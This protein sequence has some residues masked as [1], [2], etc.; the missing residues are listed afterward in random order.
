MDVCAFVGVAPRGP[1]RAPYTDEDWLESGLDPDRLRGSLDDSTCVDPA[2][3]RRRSV[4]VAV[5]SWD[6]YTRLF[7]GFEGPGRLPYAVAAY[8]NQGGRRAYI[9]RIVHDYGDGSD[10]GTA[11]GSLDGFSIDGHVKPLVLRA[12]NEG[13]WGSTL[14]AACSFA[15]SPLLFTAASATQLV[16]P[17]AAAPVPGTLLRLRL[18]GGTAVLRIVVGADVYSDPVTRTQQATVRLSYTAGGTPVSAET[19]TASLELDD[20]SG[21]HENYAGLALGAV[22]PQRIAAV[23][24]SSS[25]LV[26]ADAAW[27]NADLV[28]VD[29]SLP[30]L[31]TAPGAFGQ[32]VDAYGDIVPDDF[33]DAHWLPGDEGPASGVHALVGIAEVSSVVTPDLYEPAPLP[34]IDAILDPLDLA[35][36]DFEPCVEP[37]GGPPQEVQPPELE[38]LLLDPNDPAELAQI[39]GYQQRL[40]ELADQLA[41]FIVLLDVPPGLDQRR[42]VTWRASFGSMFCAA[43]HPWLDVAQSTDRRTA[44]VRLNPSAYGAGIIA[45][46]EWLFGVPFGPS[47]ELAVGAVD[48]ADDVSPARHDELH[49]LGI[50]VFLRRRDGIEL[51]AARTLSRDPTYRQLSVRRLVTMLERT[52][53]QELQWV[54]FEPNNASLQAD[55]RHLLR[56]YLRRLYRANAFAGATEDE[57]F[58]VRCDA[59]L[60]TQAVLDAG[61]LIAQIGIAPAEPLEF[62]VVQLTHAGDGTLVAEGAG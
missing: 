62:L 33:F 38:G 57:A 21:R 44:T 40:V 45:Q 11:Q 23:L 46:R 4:A 3:P 30:A 37:V 47:N 43:Y 25:E 22:H 56:T 8:F 39:V 31:V 59:T 34:D 35:G 20:G 15:A 50:N 18:A 1:A 17:A 6:E 61:Q 36:P 29:A 41:S 42:I 49:P 60:N 28:P 16:L 10:G 58:F 53:S 2:R 5:E 24:C 14:S 54:V 13:S 52:L 48:V 27:A 12:R 9:V 26:Y 7:G 32:V 51:A 19:V 55:L